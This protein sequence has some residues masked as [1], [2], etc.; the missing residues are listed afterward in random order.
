MTANSST[1]NRKELRLGK[2]DKLLISYN[3]T[4]SWLFLSSG[5]DF[6]FS[7]RGSENQ[8]YSTLAGF[9]NLNFENISAL[10]AID[11]NAVEVSGFLVA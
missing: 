8:Q 7:L 3:I 6:I 2:V 5:F 9:A 4:N 10:S 1:K 11:V